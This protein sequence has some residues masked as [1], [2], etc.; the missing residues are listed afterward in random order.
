MI[1]IYSIRDY[2]QTYA[3]LQNQAFLML[4]THLIQSPAFMSWKAVLM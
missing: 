3:A 4:T 1:I 2:I